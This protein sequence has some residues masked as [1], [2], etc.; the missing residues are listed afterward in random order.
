VLSYGRELGTIIDF[1]NVLDQR[2]DSK[3]PLSDDETYHRQ[4]FKSVQ[5]A[6]TLIHQLQ[7]GG[8]QTG[9]RYPV[10]PGGADPVL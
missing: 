8:K 9:L 5:L 3:K 2:L 4:K 6:D 7:A 1:L 10:K